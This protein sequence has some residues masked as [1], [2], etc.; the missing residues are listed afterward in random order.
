MQ[1]LLFLAHRLP[2]PPNKGD[3]VRSYHLLRQ[4]SRRWRVH[5]GSFVDDPADAPF[6]SALRELT[7]GQVFAPRLS[8]R[9]SRALSL[10]ALGGRRSCTEAYYAHRGM[11]A[12]VKRLLGERGVGHAVVFSSGMAQYLM[13]AKGL[14]RV[15]DLVD[16]DSE[17]WRQ[18][19]DARWGPMAAFYRREA[20]CLLALE[21]RAAAQFDATVLVSE[22]EADLFRRR[23]PESA[24]RVTVMRNGV[25]TEFF[26]PQAACADPYDGRGA[27]VVVFTGAMDYWPNVQAV[28][29][30][31]QQV[32]PR[33][34][35]VV[36]DALF[37]VVGRDP[38][39]SVRQLANYSGVKVT[40]TVQDV[41]PYLAHAAV[42]VAP[43]IVARGIQNK[44]LEA[45]AMARP[46]V[47]SP[48]A[49]EGLSVQVP[50]EALAAADAAQFSSEVVA[51]LGVDRSALGV[52]ARRAV[53]R[54]YSWEASLASLD[55]LLEPAPSVPQ[56]AVVSA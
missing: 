56:D 5:V 53:V 37:Y 16:V 7:T 38:S 14:R 50:R 13:D 25:D 35:A 15:L 48:Q 46:V 32:L 10:R 41:R 21:R 28:T 39:R 42:A 43:L 6:V 52:A 36:P 11:A 23:A 34:Q 26:D 19:A 9:V 1:E 47:A 24:D 2:Y 31:A 33:V 22:P 17:K 45:M 27:R 3:K 54:D 30:F 44:V 4:L 12:W 20:T 18:Y 51:C 8:P 49:L 55:A 29:W 40:G